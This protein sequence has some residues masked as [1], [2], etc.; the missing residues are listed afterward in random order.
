MAA[1]LGD[2]RQP[3]FG[4]FYNAILT[5]ADGG[6][7]DKLVNN[8]DAVKN[9]FTIFPRQDLFKLLGDLSAKIIEEEDDNKLDEF[10]IFYGALMDYYEN[11]RA[12][13]KNFQIILD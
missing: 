4:V 5:L 2:V 11:N 10:K 7:R 9:L 13:I 8:H 1:A 12:D 6:H 3:D